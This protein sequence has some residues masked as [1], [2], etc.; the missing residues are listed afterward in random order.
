MNRRA[1]KIALL[2]VVVAA[3]AGVTLLALRG[4]VVRNAIVTAELLVA[5]APIGGTV[6]RFELRRGRQV[7]AG[8][9]EVAIHDALADQRPLEDAQRQI[10]RLT[11]EIDGQQARLAW[12]DQQR[13][14]LQRQ[15]G[16][17]LAALKL[18]L[19]LEHQRREA[20]REAVRARIVYLSSE[21][22]RLQRLQGTAT[23]RTSI[24]LA[25]ADLVAAQHSLEALDLL[26]EQIQQRLDFLDRSLVLSELPDQPL[27]LAAHLRTLE[28]H[29][30]QV[31]ADIA[32]LEAE[33]VQEQRHLESEWRQLGL[34]TDAIVAAPEGTL[35]WETFVGTGEHVVEGSALFSYV[36]CDSLL[37]LAAV[38]DASLELIQAGHGVTISLYG[39]DRDLHGRVLASFGSTG[40]FVEQ[41]TLAAHLKDLGLTE[42]VVLIEIDDEPEEAAL[43]RL[44]DIGRTATIEFE[45]LGLLDPLLNRL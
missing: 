7:T 44:C 32:R 19:Q 42:G 27:D 8:T 28:L 13:A 43:H 12:L 33:L 35:V 39:T 11:S 30:Q 31:T 34:A 23:S 4:F 20:E 29:R 45:G 16:W 2:L 22:E 17:S 25:Q 24:E 14:E 36:R 9:A 38:D 10:D 6:T 26:L 5:R 37:A 15:L 21:Y 18:D 1:V 40:D 41:R 3:V